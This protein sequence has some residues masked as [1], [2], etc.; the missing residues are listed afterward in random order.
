V[1]LLSVA[2]AHEVRPELW[3]PNLL[4]GALG[5]KRCA[6]NQRRVPIDL[7]RAA[8]FG[9]T[10]LVVAGCTGP[11][12]RPQSPE[13]RLDLPPTPDVTLVSEYTHPFGVNYVKVEAVS[14]VTG[15]P[16]TGSDPPP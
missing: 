2:A 7:N 1:F 14:L 8:W 9:A 16:G 5:M 11:I 10:V 15:L 3:S 6:P 13:S 4:P 12:F